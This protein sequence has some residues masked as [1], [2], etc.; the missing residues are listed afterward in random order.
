MF[1]NGISGLSGIT[2]ISHCI[3][4]WNLPQ[5]K[6][7]CWAFRK[8]IYHDISLM[9][10]DR[11]IP[12]FPCL[13][14]KIFKYCTSKHETCTKVRLDAGHSENI[15]FENW[16]WPGIRPDP[17]G[18]SKFFNVEFNKD[19]SI[20]SVSKLQYQFNN[21]FILKKLKLV[22]GIMVISQSWSLF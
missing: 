3:S 22:L 15:Y 11:K 19:W 8:Y 16:F 7:Q 9:I 1:H 10:S 21:N 5:S 12:G 2:P 18:I 13:F 6:T 14:Y 17:A 4:T 20:N